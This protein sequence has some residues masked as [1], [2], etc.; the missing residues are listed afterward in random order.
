MRTAA[1]AGRCSGALEAH[2]LRR[3]MSLHAEERHLPLCGGLPSSCLLNELLDQCLGQRLALVLHERWLDCPVI[4]EGDPGDGAAFRRG[5]KVVQ[6]CVHAVRG[7]CPG[8]AVVPAPEV[9]LIAR[10]DRRAAG[11]PHRHRT[12]VAPDSR[13][14]ERHSCMCT[15]VTLRRVMAF[16]TARYIS[17]TR[18]PRGI[19]RR[20]VPCTRSPQTSSARCR[21]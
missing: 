3:V 8:H 14:W 2:H 18:K 11:S 10:H 9:P 12:T 17:R 13:V 1:S 15:S 20:R 19:S 7:A 5:S 4:R 16:S 21:P 6:F